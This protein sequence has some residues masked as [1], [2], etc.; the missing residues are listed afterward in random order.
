MKIL[1]WFVA[2]IVGFI[3]SVFA[4]GIVV[5]VGEMSAW[6]PF[7]LA[8]GGVASAFCFIYL[9]VKISGS[10]SIRSVKILSGVTI[11]T[12][13]ISVAGSYMGQS[14]PMPGLGLL[15]A[16]WV[17]FKNPDFFVKKQ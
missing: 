15:I 1:R 11:F 6:V 4:G 3:A 8:A 5:T 14:S 12:A 13:L 7:P 16:G 2:I 10:T 9:S 17:L